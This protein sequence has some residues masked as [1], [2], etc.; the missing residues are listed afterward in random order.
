ME[1]EMPKVS[2]VV[3]IYKSE[4]FLDKLILSLIHQTYENI[5]I[6][7]VDDGSPDGSG[8]I[9]DKYAAQDKRIC[10]IHKQ[11]GG[12]CEAR[13]VG[14]EKASGEYMVIVDGDDWLETDYVEY[15]M[16]LIQTTGS[17]MA[18]SDKIFTTRDR[19]QTKE[20]K[21][22]TW[23]AEEAACAI[24][25][26]RIA[27]G[28]WNKIY[29]T[30][31]LRENNISFSVKWSGEGLHFSCVAAQHA[32]HVGVG[33]RKV[34][35]YRLNNVNS[36]LTHYNLQMGLNAFENIRI[37][38][39][40][41]Y[42]DSEKLR[43]ACDWHIWKNYGYI[44]FL[45]IATDSKRENLALYKDCRKNLLL[46]LPKVLVKSRVGGV[47]NFT[48]FFKDCSLHLS[49]NEGFEKNGRHC[50]RIRWNNK[51]LAPYSGGNAWIS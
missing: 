7:L 51:S 14:M 9:C 11:N 34:Y 20:D 41:L 1:K 40:T 13:N 49:Q 10:V 35:N 31:L 3:A 28:P 30:K 36:G 47:Q 26:P 21:I 37:I 38:K 23:T 18:M 42:L 46:R 6:I 5:E 16:M 25:Y 50:K 8:A 12:A 24:I 48:C 15:M 44:L 29:S 17:D 43:T 4:K 45:I 22:E 32:N 39:D 33:H 19:V 27:I 2:I